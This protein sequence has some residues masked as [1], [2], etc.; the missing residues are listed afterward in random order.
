MN[1]FGCCTRALLFHDEIQGQSTST[2]GRPTRTD[3][4]S[5]P[6]Q[7]PGRGTAVISRAEVLVR[8]ISSI[9]GVLGKAG[10][11]CLIHRIHK[12][13]VYVVHKGGYRLP[14]AGAQ[15][16][17]ESCPVRRS[18]PKQKPGRLSTKG[19]DTS[20]ITEERCELIHVLYTLSRPSAR[21]PSICVAQ[22]TTHVLR[23]N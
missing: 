8:R 11:Q 7:P 21:R 2:V 4:E 20:G 1:K 14:N 12:S 5:Q 23:P 19:V 3:R 6:R 17:A 9:W 15:N 22:R 10:A 16:S 13:T 18:G